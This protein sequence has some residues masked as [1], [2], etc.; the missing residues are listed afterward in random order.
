MSSLGRFKYM[1]LTLSFLANAAT[2]PSGYVGSKVCFGCHQGIY[3]SFLQTDMG[4]S[5]RP[6]ADIGASSLPA[7]ATVPVGSSDRTLRV[8][9]DQVGWHQSESEPNVFVEQFPLEYVVGSGENGLTF[10]IRRGAYLFQAPLSFYS[11]IDKW[12]LSPGYETVD[13][14]FTRPA[15][16]A[17]ITCHTGR[18][19]AV[20]NQG[21]EYGDPAF[22]QL[23][24]GCENCHGPGSAHIRSLGRANLIVN[25]AKLP[26]RRAE[27][28]C[29][30]C[31]QRG[32]TRVL[33]EG[34][35][36]SDFRPGQPLLET[37]AIFKAPRNTNAAGSDLLEHDEA[38][39]ASRC[40][41][42]SDGRLS[43]FTC[44]DPHTQP[45]GPDTFAYFRQKCMTCHT[46]ASC[47]LPLAARI[48][49]HPADNCIG[50]H[51]PKRDVKVISHSALTNHMIPATSA[52]AVPQQQSAD[53][54]TGLILI[55]KPSQGEV[56]VSSVTLLR[57]YS[58]LAPRYPAYQDRYL[59]LLTQLS[60]SDS[61]DL[62]SR[63]PFVQAALG[64]KALSDGK[65]QEALTH[66][67]AAL[68]LDEAT[69]YR[70]IAQALTNL[71]RGDEAADYLKRAAE[72]F[73]FD[74]VVSKSL[75]LNYIN[76]KRYV[77]AR[78]AMEQYVKLFPADTFMRNLL[79]RVSH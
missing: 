24:I 3:R 41:R 76:S 27:D 7:E 61:H 45:R 56:P 46:D 55:D 48:Q 16:E 69:V 54:Q 28:I 4:R 2:D 30:D 14:G 72:S 5:M 52:E 6:A 67:S 71:G 18:S 74:P 78:Q 10:L 43:C 65:N 37:L 39:K 13:L 68:S 63:A 29:M 57:A 26:V 64:H 11:K 31:H 32:D 70:D 19:N 79:A 12:D 40:F 44:H 33:Q 22:Q 9:H 49:Q 73:P 21:N 59:A 17:C 75:I 42:A 1:I 23:S 53:P 35:S 8:Y 47:R 51:M 25:P 58:E 20:R 34:K 15:P 77:E 38:M 50:C 62:D 66:L 60:T 36:F